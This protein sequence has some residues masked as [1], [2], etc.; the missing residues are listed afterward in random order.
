MRKVY[1]FILIIIV[2]PLMAVTCYYA[3]Q[4][5]AVVQNDAEKNYEIELYQLL[6]DESILLFSKE[7]SKRFH[8]CKSIKDSKT[9]RLYLNFGELTDEH[10]EVKLKKT[11]P[12]ILKIVVISNDTIEKKFTIS[13]NMKSLH[14]EL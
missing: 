11:E 5:L 3:A 6:D 12:I 2:L 4:T 13:E 10:Y 9:K 1:L 14:I 8:L 7:T